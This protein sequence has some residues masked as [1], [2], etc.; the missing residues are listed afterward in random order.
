M[1]KLV[2]LFMMIIGLAFTGCE[3]MED[4]HE[5]IDSDLEEGVE[6]SVD[7]VLTEEDYEALDLSYG[8]FN[9]LDEAGEL[10]PSL[11]TNHFP[12]WGEGSLVN[13]TFDLYDPIRFDEYTVASSEYAE[14]GLEENY[15]PG[16]GD[17]EDFLFFKF[18][19]TENGDYV[20]LTYQVLSDEEAYDFTDD[21]FDIV[22]EE[23]GDTYPDP[24]SSAAQYDNFEK[25]DGNDAYW[26]NEMILEAINVVLSENIEGVTGQKYNVSYSTYDGSPGTES[27]TVQFDGNAY[28]LAS[29]TAYELGDADFDLI[30]EELGDEY[31]DPT[32]NAAQHNSFDI[33]S[34]GDTSWSEDMILEALNIVLMEEDPAATNGAKYDVSYRVFS[35][36]VSTVITSVVMV[37]GVYVLDEEASVSTIEETNVFAFTNGR[38]NAPLTLDS[39]DYTDMGQSYPNFDDEDEAIY[40]LELYLGEVYPYAEEGDFAA[41]AYDFYSGSTSTRYDNFIFEGGKWNY[42][43]SVIEQTIQFG[44]D[45]ETWEPDNTITYT[46][47]EADFEFIGDALIDTYPGPADNAGYFGSF[48]RRST[49]DN[50]WGNEMI[51]EALNLFLDNLDP[52]AE[53]GQRYVVTYEVYTGSTGFES[54][55][56]IKEDGEW[57]LNE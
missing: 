24:A 35:G 51:L 39:E 12:V 27:M 26:S 11:L 22:E 14:I 21:D 5:E 20:E 40:K 30:Q 42:I 45:G 53:E 50:Y 4:I 54:M 8:S 13:V 6:G 44:H 31:P 15:F 16:F 3:T 32:A 52:N 7:Y 2:Y 37:D 57:V 34:G 56:V 10:I 43:P 29:G 48:D 1:K 38:W 47:T 25:R 46:L 33:R 19:Q 23:L 18:P 28:I 49:S 55:S 17:I 36:G 41:L 9:S